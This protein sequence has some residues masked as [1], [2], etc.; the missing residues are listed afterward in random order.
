M[1]Y[2]RNFSDLHLQALEILAN[3]LQ[4][5][6][7]LSL[8]D[9][10][11]HLK[12]RVRFRQWLKATLFRDV[13]DY[14][15]LVETVDLSDQSRNEFSDRLVELKSM[16]QAAQETTVNQEKNLIL[17]ISHIKLAYLAVISRVEG[18]RFAARLYEQDPL[19]PTTWV[20]RGQTQ[21]GQADYI[22]ALGDLTRFFHNLAFAFQNNELYQA[23]RDLYFTVS[24]DFA[25]SENI[26]DLD[27]AAV[28]TDELMDLDAIGREVMQYLRH[29]NRQ[30][31]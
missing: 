17:V 15:Q 12:E 7:G 19:S 3:T 1:K 21:I 26:G 8:R 22:L 4:L 28:V 23:V 24:F 20:L 5:D 25:Q 31:N 18:Y 29:L 10:H 6:E 30:L 16:I 11:Y 14:T 9:L 27:R 13:W 2:L